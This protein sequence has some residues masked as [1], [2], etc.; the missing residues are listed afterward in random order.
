ME[1]SLQFL[2]SGLYGP[3][4]AVHLSNLFGMRCRLGEVR[5]KGQDLVAI[6]RGLFKD[7]AD[8]TVP[9]YISVTISDPDPLL[10]DRTALTTPDKTLFTIHFPR[11]AFVLATD[12]VG[13]L[14]G[15]AVKKVANTEV[16]VYDREITCNQRR[17]H[18]AQ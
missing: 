2:K 12:K 8:S 11:Q 3:A 6:T 16:A 5:Q 10:I 1:V 17:Q 15:D 9:L 18:L 13:L 7:D 14:V 4:L